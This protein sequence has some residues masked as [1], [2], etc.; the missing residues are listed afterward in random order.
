MDAD[1]YQ[2]EKIAN[3]LKNATKSETQDVEHCSLS[4]IPLGELAR[5][6]MRNEVFKQKRQADQG[7][8][9]SW[10][11]SLASFAVIAADVYISFTLRLR[12]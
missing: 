6:K 8:L 4:G 11:S 12:N 5:T 9:E 2:K 3:V 7:C 10:I 1:V